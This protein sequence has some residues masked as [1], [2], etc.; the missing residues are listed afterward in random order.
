M[1]AARRTRTQ[2]RPHSRN[3]HAALLRAAGLRVTAARLAALQTMQEVLR[4]EG[5]LTPQALHRAATAHGYT[6]SVSAFHRVLP[7]LVAGGLLPA[8][9]LH[10]PGAD[11]TPQT[12]TQTPSPRAGHAAGAALPASE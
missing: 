5:H 12:T 11:S 1:S 9:A 6:V 2:Q 7:A 4:A 8:A 3:P 10:P